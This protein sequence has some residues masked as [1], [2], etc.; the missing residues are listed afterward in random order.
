MDTGLE[1]IGTNAHE[2]PMVYAAVARDEA[3]LRQAPYAV[4]RDWAT[5]Y[6][7]NLLVVLPDCFGTTA[8]LRNATDLGR[9]L[10]G[11]ASRFRSRRSR[12]RAS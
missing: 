9:R 1:A 5:M 11:R 2:L 10:G 4:L 3:E 12:P 6:G 7:G 8:F